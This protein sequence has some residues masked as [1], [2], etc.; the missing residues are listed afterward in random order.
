MAHTRRFRIIKLYFLI[1][2][3]GTTGIRRYIRNHIDLARLFE[4]YVRRDYRFEVVGGPFR[5]G[6]VAFRLKGY[7]LLTT[8]LVDA[9]NASHRIHLVPS[10]FH[11]QVVIRFALCAEHANEAD[12]G[13][14][15]SL[16]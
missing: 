3:Y 2:N 16:L 7:N 9:L 5:F 10:H 1:R 11:N 8:R 13:M 14:M 12:V 4:N 15:K 6:L